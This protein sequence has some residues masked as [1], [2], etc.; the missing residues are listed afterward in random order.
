MWRRVLQISWARSNSI[1]FAGLELGSAI[2]MRG[3]EFCSSGGLDE[4]RSFV[5]AHCRRVQ[6]EDAHKL[7]ANAALEAAAQSARAAAKSAEAVAKST[8]AAAE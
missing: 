6:A 4:V 7:A 2:S 1:E 3:F 8:Q 5:D